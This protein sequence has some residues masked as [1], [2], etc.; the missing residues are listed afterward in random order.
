MAD[1]P[2]TDAQDVAETFD[3]D[4]TNLDSSRLKGG[5]DAEQ[6]E[7]L[8]DVYDATQADGDADEDEPEI[9]DDMDDDEI[10]GSADDADSDDDDASNRAAYSDRTLDGGRKRRGDEV[11][12]TY[13]GDLTNVSAGRASTADMESES[14][15]DDDL[16]ELHYQE[17]AK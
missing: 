16:K 8:P 15:D 2:E 9:G 4:N 12:L 1:M 5:P 6:F 13:A 7:D 17:D 3:E 11:E 14:L 10:V